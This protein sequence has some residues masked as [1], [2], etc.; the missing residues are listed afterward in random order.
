MLRIQGEPQQSIC[1]PIPC[2]INLNISN[3]QTN[4][5]YMVLLIQDRRPPNGN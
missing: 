1:Y 4:P 2:V 5:F 3:R